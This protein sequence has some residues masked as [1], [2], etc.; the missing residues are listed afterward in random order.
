M[1]K[2]KKISKSYKTGSFFQKALNEVSVS[3]REKEFVAILGSSG[4]GKTTLLNIVG[5]LDV[6]DYGDLVF[7]NKS[8]KKF[9]S[10]DWD[11]YR[12]NSIGFVFQNYNLIS[13]ISVLDNVQLGMTL[14]GKSKSEREEKALYLLDKVGIKEHS[15]KKPNQLSG[16][17]MQRVA[18]ARALANDPD[19]ILAD[20]PT[21]ALDSKTGD[22][23]LDLISEVAKDKLVIM[24]THD[25]AMANKYAKRIIRLKDGEVLDDSDPYNDKEDSSLYKLKKTSMNFLTALN[26]SFKNIITKKGR[27]A[28]TAFASSIGIIGIALVLS[29]SNGFDKQIEQF[30]IDTLS[31]FP[32][33][34]SEQQMEIN[35]NTFRQDRE[36]EYPDTDFAISTN[37]N[38]EMMIHENDI[39]EEYFEYVSSIDPSLL[40]GITYNWGTTL[41]ILRKTED[42]VKVFTQRDL[43]FTTLP[44]Q[45]DESDAS[46]LEKGYDLLGGELPK[47]PYELVIQL[48]TKNRIDE[49]LLK[50]LGLEGEEV[51]FDELIGKTFKIAANDDFYI[52]GEPV[53]ARNPDLNAVYDSE[54]AIKLTVVGIVRGKEDNLL[55]ELVGGQPW[56]GRILFSSE[57]QEELLDLNFNSKIVQNQLDQDR[58]VLTNEVLDQDD[59]VNALRML[60]FSETP[61]MINIFP[62]DFE[63]KDEIISILDEYNEGVSDE[64]KIVYNDLAETI[65]SLSSSIMNAITLVLVAFSAISLVVSSIM[66]GIITYI[67]VIERTKEIGVLR[68]LGA[69]KKDITRVFNAETFIIGVNSGILGL[70]I[71]RLLIFP[72]NDYIE[73]AT[74]LENVAQM[75]VEHIIILMLV[76]IILTLIGGFIPSKMASRKDPVEALRTE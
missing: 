48:D 40:N 74:E 43:F 71:A 61:R 19:I 30:E 65:T 75:S 15:H 6:Y 23:I 33:M 14:S 64:E 16:G 5:G 69:R 49:N 11:A 76:S 58:S 21:G 54:D 50:V 38:E 28:L 46:F 63:S 66:I 7:N 36:G 67:S 55:S 53:F 8:T 56:P 29:L 20:E 9:K 31:S 10:K 27:T 34:I 62:R 60:G 52:E 25:S 13:H 12:N 17:Q 39:T 68:A 2:L 44:K 3:F 51:S 45:V 47:T 24:V 73:S 35:E 57:L 42:E 70:T 37:V 72:I 32:I 59:K 4:S 41:N 18:I 22:K 26:L 1:L